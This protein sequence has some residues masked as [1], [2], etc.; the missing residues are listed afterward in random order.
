LNNFS[1]TIGIKPERISLV[2]QAVGI[3]SLFQCEQEL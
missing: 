3:L 2:I 1:I